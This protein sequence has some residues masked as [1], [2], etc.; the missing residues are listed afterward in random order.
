[1]NRNELIA[2]Q[3]ERLSDDRIAY[4]LQFVAEEPECGFYNDY[5][6][7]VASEENGYALDTYFDRIC[8]FNTNDVG[9]ALDFINAQI[10]FRQRFLEHLHKRPEFIRDDGMKRISRTM[11]MLTG[12]QVYLRMQTSSSVE[13]LESVLSDIM[14]RLSPVFVQHFTFGDEGPQS[15]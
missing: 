8:L 7:I 14:D 10:G 2:S 13:N 3:I 1:M 6:Q 11:T 12:A 4:M 5:L 9:Q 15:T